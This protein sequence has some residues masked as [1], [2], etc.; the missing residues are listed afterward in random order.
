MQPISFVP[1]MVGN[2]DICNAFEE[3]IPQLRGEECKSKMEAM[4]E[5]ATTDTENSQ[6]RMTTH[7]SEQDP[8]RSIFVG[9]LP[10]EVMCRCALAGGEQGAA[11]K[12]HADLG[13]VFVFLVP[14]LAMGL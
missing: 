1:L 14:R 4:G 10:Q 9:G 2:A 3:C 7:P 12:E 6:R 8:H 11:T 5:L 13:C